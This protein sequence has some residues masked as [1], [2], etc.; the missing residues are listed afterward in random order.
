MVAGLDNF[1]AYYQARDVPG[2]G[3]GGQS[4]YVPPDQQPTNAFI[5]YLEGVAFTVTNIKYMALATLCISAY[6][7]AMCAWIFRRTL[8]YFM[9]LAISCCTGIPPGFPPP[10]PPY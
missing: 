1:F 9:K 2:G 6:N 5:T 4:S 10:A 7:M 8:F 3:N